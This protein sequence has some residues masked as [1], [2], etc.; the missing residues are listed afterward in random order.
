MLQPDD[1]LQSTFQLLYDVLAPGGQVLLSDFEC[2]SES[3][4]FHP[5][6]QHSDVERHGMKG[7]DLTIY[8]KQAGFQSVKVE[9]S[10]TL[11]KGCEDGVTRNFPFLIVRSCI[12]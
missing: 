4:W 5:S 6:L 1:S 12:S 9:K 8:L 7:A 11:P 3:Q 10:F 2:N